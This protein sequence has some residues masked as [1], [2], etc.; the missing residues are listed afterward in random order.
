M[1]VKAVFVP[2]P[3]SDWRV[4]NLFK[5]NQM[6]GFSFTFKSRLLISALNSELPEVGAKSWRGRKCLKITFQP[7]FTRIKT[8]RFPYHQKHTKHYIY[9]ISSCKHISPEN[10]IFANVSQRT[11][12]SRHDHWTILAL[13]VSFQ[14]KNLIDDQEFSFQIL[15]FQKI[16]F[17]HSMKCF[18]FE[19]F[20]RS[21]SQINWISYGKF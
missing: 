8:K 14:I 15:W 17:A 6:L 21:C 18:N 20:S 9:L 10:F 13:L 16:L 4:K 7:I 1:K 5:I 11:W 2:N 12:F 3:S 19:A